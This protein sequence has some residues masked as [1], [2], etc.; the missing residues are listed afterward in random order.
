L[1]RLLAT[2]YDDL[3]NELK[4]RWG[5]GEF[6]AGALYREFFR[7]GRPAFRQAP[8][9][10]ASPRLVRLLTDHIDTRLPEVVAVRREGELTK[11]VTR[12]AD[13]EQTESVIIPMAT[14]QTVCI[15]SQVGCRM[16]CVFCATARMG[17]RRNLAADEIVAQV[18]L[19][20]FYFQRP[21]R[22]VVFMGM[23][24]P[25]DNFEPVQQAIRVLSDQRGLNIA[26][27]HITLST[28]GHPEGLR[29][30]AAARSFPGVRL[31]VSL[32]APNDRL[33]S[34]IMPV[35][36]ALPM[37]ALRRRLLQLAEKMQNA[38]FVEYVL[39]EG[40]NDDRRCARQLARYLKPLPAKVNLIAYNPDPAL[41]WAA[42]S[43]AT[44]ERFRQWLVEEG[45]FVRLRSARGRQVTAACG[46]LY[47]RFC[48][49]AAP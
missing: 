33:R 46:Q 35:N 14:H 16:G 4:Q 15:S 44:I 42:P 40:C 43:G 1:L 7:R 38:V 22:N 13:G 41:P 31:A 30:L 49:A 17:L 21:V 3:V 11:F 5:K 6:H 34:R 23:G 10:A 29:R 48:P 26:P 36:R 45:L 39:L 19:A 9:L 24:E 27:R 25:L 32:N 28:A 2:P 47:H 20:R 12:L 37:E 18:Y 8:E